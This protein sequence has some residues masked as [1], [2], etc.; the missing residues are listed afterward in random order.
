MT[1]RG[2]LF[3]L[4]GTLVHTDP[5]HF[6]AW[7]ETLRTRGVALDEEAYARRV[8]GRHNPEIVA[9][10]LPDL[11][12]TEGRT[13]SDAKEARF[14]ELATE[15]TPLPG[16]H[17]LLRAARTAGLRT[18]VVTNAPRDNAVFMLE[19]LGLSDHFDVLALAEDAAAAKP[20]PAPYREVLAR[21]GL[22]P[23]EA[24][25]FEDSPSGIRSAR[26][27]GLRVVGVA[28]TQPRAVLAAQGAARVIMD[29]QDERLWA[30][31]L[32]FLHA[33]RDEHPRAEG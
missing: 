20:D 23:D 24:L 8:S 18:A 33:H 15:L 14:R 12:A 26:G 1:L 9:E 32:A 17:S 25:A 30:G 10:L 11:S 4:D 3:D 2:L 21:L 29:F 6:R 19:A 7:R 5:V 27:A 22:T 28:T 31:P 13:F 16:V